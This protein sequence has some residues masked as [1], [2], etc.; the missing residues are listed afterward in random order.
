MINCVNCSEWFHPN[1]LCVVGGHIP[2]EFFCEFCMTEFDD[3]GSLRGSA[4]SRCKT[5]SELLFDLMAL[6]DYV[7]ISVSLQL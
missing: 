3:D 1:Y 5:H 6:I 4:N 2:S 7:S